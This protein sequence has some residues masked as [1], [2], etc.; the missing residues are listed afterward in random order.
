MIL[1]NLT[2]S[3]SFDEYH[4]LL[5]ALRDKEVSLRADMGRLQRYVEDCG[6]EVKDYSLRLIDYCEKDIE[7]LVRLQEKVKEN[8]SPG[9]FE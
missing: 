1:T 4:M 7:V 8:S 3:F 6:A 5:E 2:V 9:G